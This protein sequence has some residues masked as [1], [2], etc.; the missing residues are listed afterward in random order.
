MKY[1][2]SAR[3]QFEGTVSKV[4]EGAVNGIVTIDVNGTPVTA[5][6]SMGS[7][8]NLDIKPGVK[9]CAVVKATEVMVGKGKLQLSARN[10][11]PGKVIAIEEGA[12]NAIVKIEALGGN[13]VTSTISLAA[14]KE[15]G[16]KVGEEA[17]AV[18][19]ATSVMVGI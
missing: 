14:V 7:I 5:T 8:K 11:F 10:Q 3:N 18:I 13:T 6:I 4:T 1:A 19:K 12:V 16:L 9:A 15:L 2:L 17:T